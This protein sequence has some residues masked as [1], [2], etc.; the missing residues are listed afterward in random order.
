MKNFVAKV[1]DLVAEVGVDPRSF[2][3]EITDG[4]LLGDDPETHVM[5]AQLRKH[6]F[7]LAFDDFGTGYSSLSYWQRYPINRIKIDQSFVA[8]LGVSA[9]SEA[10]IVAIVK[11]ARALRLAVIAEGVETESQQHCLASA[12][13]TDMQGYLFSKPLPAD[14]IDLLWALPRKTA[15]AA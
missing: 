7:E 13:C 12:G 4:I 2:E 6:G 11:L 15:L 10:F 9:D 14:E 8:N 3:L 5:V 1:M